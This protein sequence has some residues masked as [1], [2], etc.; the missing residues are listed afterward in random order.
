MSV[1]PPSSGANQ[2]AIQ[3]QHAAAAKSPQ[4][5]AARAVDGPLAGCNSHECCN[6]CRS[7][8]IL[9]RGILDRIETNGYNNFTKRAYVPKWQK[10]LTLP[11]A[12]ARSQYAPNLSRHIRELAEKAQTAP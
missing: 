9:Y 8:L 12:F 4:P 1:F 5:H 10:M 7:A 6:S 2:A 3:P 11:A